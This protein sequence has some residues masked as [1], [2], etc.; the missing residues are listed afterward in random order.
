M[1][2][3]LLPGSHWGMMTMC[4]P[5]PLSH[6]WHF[7]MQQLY[8]S[9]GDTYTAP[10][11]DGAGSDLFNMMV[12]VM[13]AAQPSSHHKTFPRCKTC[14]P[15]QP[16]SS[17]WL[18]IPREYTEWAMDKFQET[19]GCL[20]DHSIAYPTWDKFAK[21]AHKA[22]D[23]LSIWGVLPDCWC[24]GHLGVGDSPDPW[25]PCH[26]TWK[27]NSCCKQSF[28]LHMEWTQLLFAQHHEHD[29]TGP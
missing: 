27:V 18:M 25:W 16:A 6:T 23:P 29:V 11:K 1:S 9:S 4:N 21:L 13:V 26:H 3:P 19:T 24:L 20:V 2:T 14:T 17:V 7:Q 15:D 5:H 10:H 8:T 28:N 22:D 12:M